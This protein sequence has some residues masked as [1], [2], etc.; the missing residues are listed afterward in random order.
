M[1]DESDRT[2]SASGAG[3]SLVELLTVVAI[4]GI[5]AAFSF[6]AIGQYIRNYKIRGASEQ[7]AGA[8]QTARS[9]AIVKNVNLGVDFVVESPT[10]YWVHVEDDQSAAHS[11]TPKTLDFSAPNAAQSTSFTLPDGVQFAASAAQCPSSTLAKVNQSGSFGPTGGSFGF[12]RLGAWCNTSCGSLTASPTPASLLM[13]NTAGTVVC[14]Y[15]PNTGLSRAL[16]VSPGGR[17]KQQQ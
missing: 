5:L 15:Q 7:V 11:R 12:S 6:P 8:I 2:R 3:F 14:L 16:V 10:R 17:I 13:N 4:I 1:K 9:R